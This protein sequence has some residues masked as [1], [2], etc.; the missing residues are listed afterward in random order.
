MAETEGEEGLTAWIERYRW[1]TW[2][3][4]LGAALFGVATLAGG[5]R[6]QTGGL[7]PGFPDSAAAMFVVL[8]ATAT[9][10][11]TG[12]LLVALGVVDWSRL[13]RYTTARIS[14][15]ERRRIRERREGEGST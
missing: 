13:R 12:R 9:I 6:W 3:V 8:A 10:L 11:W 15:E 5:W 4:T 14:P 7:Y 1:G 2:T